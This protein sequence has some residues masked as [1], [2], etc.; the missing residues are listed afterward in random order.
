MVSEWDANAA[1][2]LSIAALGISGIMAVV[3]GLSWRR[4]RHARL[5][6]VAAAFG[7]L[8]AGGAWRAWNVAQGAPAELVPAALDF[9][10]VLL[11]YASVAA[12]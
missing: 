6:F 10:A 3:S 5:A 4:L 7:V 9:G 1:A 12:R 8:A 2:F 11:L